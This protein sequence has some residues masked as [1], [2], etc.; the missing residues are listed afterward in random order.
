M[1]TNYF[2]KLYKSEKKS[3]KESKNLE[4]QKMDYILKISDDPRGNNPEDFFKADEAVLCKDFLAF[5]KKHKYAGSTKLKIERLKYRRPLST[6][7]ILSGSWHS[8]RIKRIARKSRWMTMW[9][10][11]GYK[12]G[13]YYN[14]MVDSAMP[15]DVLDVYLCNDG[16]LRCERSGPLFKDQH[17]FASGV[18][19]IPTDKKLFTDYVVVTGSFSPYSDHDDYTFNAR[20]INEILKSYTRQLI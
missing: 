11:R 16:K 10:G 8:S 1:K 4:K 6:T 13:I 14:P 19:R 20:P 9:R 5:M 18:G 3:K 12:L 17:S 7:R 2:E 15:M